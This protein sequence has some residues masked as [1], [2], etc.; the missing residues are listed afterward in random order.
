MGLSATA[1]AGARSAEPVAASAAP[2]GASAAPVDRPAAEILSVVASPPSVR[3]GRT[4]L[5]EI[6]TDGV[7]VAPAE[8]LALRFGPI[9]HEAA[10]ASLS[11]FGPPQPG[12][13]RLLALAGIPVDAV[14]GPWQL[15]AAPRLE[16][17]AEAQTAVV[18][19]VDGGF[20]AQRLVFAAELMSLLEPEVGEEERLTMAVGMAGPS[21]RWQG[22]FRQPVLGRVVT[23]HGARRDYLSPAGR[24]V[25]QSQ[26]GGVDLAAALG[27]PIAAAAAGVVAF[28]GRWS[29]RGNVVVVDHGT[30]VHTVHAHAS[31]LLVSAGQEVASGQVLARV[32]STGLS[33]GPHLHWELRINGVAVDPLEWTKREDLALA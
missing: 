16:P 26:H 29:I 12:G 21:P 7:P 23:S 15:S 14:P 24:I 25:A 11:V 27:T 19:V 30:G 33:T 28:A 18:D 8:S 17:D 6:E 2:I 4:V 22:T 1:L 10:P 32:G 13:T 3:Q 5:A 9:E 31:E 20:P